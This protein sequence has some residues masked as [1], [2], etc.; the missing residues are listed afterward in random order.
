M[1]GDEQY[2]STESKTNISESF[3]RKLW[4]LSKELMKEDTSQKST[5]EAD[6]YRKLFNKDRTGLIDKL[7]DDLHFD[8][9]AI[10]GE[11]EAEQQSAIDLLRFLFRIEKEKDGRKFKII[12][13]LNHPSMQ[14]LISDTPYSSYID[15]REGHQNS[16]QFLKLVED[17][18]SYV[19][20]ADDIDKTLEQI[21]WHWEFETRELFSYVLSDRAIEEPE[22]AMAE[23]ERIEYFLTDKILDRKSVV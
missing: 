11:N 18:R 22:S 17:V 12:D 4:Q 23:L 3:K 5:S 13:F 8:M 19:T 21:N 14:N 9:I 15:Y 1:R 10:I 2:M 16:A 7:K 20:D 6:C